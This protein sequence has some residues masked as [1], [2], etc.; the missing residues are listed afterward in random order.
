VRKIGSL[1]IEP[2]AQAKIGAPFDLRVRVLDP[3]GSPVR[4]L[5]P[6]RVT[7][8]DGGGALSEYGDTFAAKN[9]LWEMRGYAALND[10]AGTWSATVEDL[11]SGLR[12][13]VYFPVA[14]AGATGGNR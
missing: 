11:A 1:A 13:T 8:R 4:G 10:A 5:A 3:A 6:I 9:G 14:A 7:I 2:P 12:K